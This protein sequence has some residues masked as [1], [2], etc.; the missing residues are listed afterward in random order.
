LSR[1]RSY[2]RF[3]GFQRTQRLFGEQARGDR[4]DAERRSRLC[5]SGHPHQRGL[6]GNVNTPMATFVTKNHDPEIVGRMVAQ[7]PIGRFGEPE[8]IA[9]AVIWLCSPAASFMLGSC[10]DGRW[11][12]PRRLIEGAKIKAVAQA[13]YLRAHGQ[14]QWP[15]GILST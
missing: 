12:P 3:K 13:N 7:E 2:R 8:E 4:S 10:N 5:R 6:P 15:L 14:L 11:R 9:A 1:R